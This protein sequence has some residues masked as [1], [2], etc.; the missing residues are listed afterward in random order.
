MR[1]V[2]GE[3]GFG[4]RFMLERL[5]GVRPCRGSGEW[6]AVVVAHPDDEMIGLGSRLSE[7]GGVTL[8]YVTDGAPRDGRDS[9]GLARCA[10]T[11]AGVA[12]AAGSSRGPGE[13]DGAG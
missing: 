2:G 4:P 13:P 5:A 11:S 1:T 10:A 9:V 12:D 3:R 7:L 6:L 8:V